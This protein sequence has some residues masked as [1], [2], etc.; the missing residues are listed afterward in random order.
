[1]KKF[2]GQGRGIEIYNYFN[3]GIPLKSLAFFHFEF[4]KK[5]IKT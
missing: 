3:E 4:E 1:M 2:G 5:Y